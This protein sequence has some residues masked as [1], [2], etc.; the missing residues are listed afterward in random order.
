LSSAAIATGNLIRG[1]L[2]D[3][4]GRPIFARLQSIGAELKLHSHEVLIHL[5]LCETFSHEF[6]HHLTE[7][8]ATDLEILAAW[9]YDQP[10]ALP[11]KADT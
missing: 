8:V 7:P 10:R 1:C 4:G 11:V 6:L 2:L 3:Q 9:N 5:V